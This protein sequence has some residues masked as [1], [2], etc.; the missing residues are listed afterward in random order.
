MPVKTA[1]RFAL[2]IGKYCFRNEEMYLQQ[3]HND[4]APTHKNLIYQITEIRYG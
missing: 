1:K 4:L 3:S 2:K